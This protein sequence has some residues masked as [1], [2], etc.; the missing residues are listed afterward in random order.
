MAVV[1]DNCPSIA[2]PVSSNVPV[3]PDGYGT[4]HGNSS[5]T[6]YEC[7]IKDDDDCRTY[8]PLRDMTYILHSFRRS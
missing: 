3:P 4:F 1:T 2:P 8:A 6:A 5:P 7:I